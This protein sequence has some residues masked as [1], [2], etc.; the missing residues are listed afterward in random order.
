MKFMGSMERERIITVIGY[1][2]GRVDIKL[3]AMNRGI[4]EE[5]LG[6]IHEK[7]PATDQGPSHNSNAKSHESGIKPRHP[8]DSGKLLCINQK[9]FYL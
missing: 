3:T 4:M 9:L 5:R 2:D 1:A 8:S 7:N 6:K